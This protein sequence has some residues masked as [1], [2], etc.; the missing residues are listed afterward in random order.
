MG[1]QPVLVMFCVATA[2]PLL[3]VANAY[4]VWRKYTLDLTVKRAAD[5]SGEIIRPAPKRDVPEFYREYTASIATDE[6]IKALGAD[7]EDETISQLDITHCESTRRIRVPFFMKYVSMCKAEFGFDATNMSAANKMVARRF[8]RDAMF[9]DNVRPGT[10]T[11][12]M[13]YT[14]IAT[15]TCTNEEIIANYML[16]DPVMVHRAMHSMSPQKSFV[17]HLLHSIGGDRALTL[18]GLRVGDPLS[19][20]VE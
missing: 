9:A 17:E 19:F 8:L 10:V 12:V 11:R 16:H 18:L 15:F 5:G 14:L 20:K 2:V 13:P 4:R 1:Y 7:L 6:V 3:Y